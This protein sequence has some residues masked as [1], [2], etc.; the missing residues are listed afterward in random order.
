MA[1]KYLPPTPSWTTEVKWECHVFYRT[2]HC[3][4]SARFSRRPYTVG[5]LP[6]EAKNIKHVSFYPHGL[7]RRISQQIFLRH[8]RKRLSK[9]PREAVCSALSSPCA[10]GL[11]NFT[12]VKQN[13]SHMTGNLKTSMRQLSNNKTSAFAAGSRNLNWSQLK[14]GPLWNSDLCC[15]VKETLFIRD[16]QPSLNEYSSENLYL[17]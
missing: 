16:L 3:S 12:L 2:L 6:R 15:T 5:N 8:V 17:H 10:A 1:P 4:S 9:L 14:L 13:V 11:M 7:A